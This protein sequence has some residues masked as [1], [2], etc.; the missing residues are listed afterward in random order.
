M[1]ARRLVP[2]APRAWQFAA[3]AV[4]LTGLLAAVQSPARATVNNCHAPY[5]N[6]ASFAMSPFRTL[7]TFVTDSYVSMEKAWTG[8]SYARL[9]SRPDL[10]SIG[11]WEEYRLWCV[12]PANG[13][14]A[15]QSFGN[16]DYVSA[17]IGWTGN[18]RG[19]CARPNQT[20]EGPWETFYMDW[21][22]ISCSG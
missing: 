14:Y 4:M 17:E 9:R 7:D 10:T 15:I 21:C 5:P 6:G 19:C 11:P 12:D 18:R 8:N 13:Y 22:V 20:T 16:G 2:A 3:A 1:L